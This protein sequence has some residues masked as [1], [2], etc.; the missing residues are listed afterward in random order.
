MKQLYGLIFMLCFT[1]SSFA[2]EGG[3]KTSQFKI[4]KTEEGTLIKLYELPVSADYE[5]FDAYGNFVLKG[6]GQV[7]KCNDLPLGV[8]YVRYNDI[9]EKFELK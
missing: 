8:Y 3:G 9:T 1:A 7:I 2:Q 6:T 5:L 4:H